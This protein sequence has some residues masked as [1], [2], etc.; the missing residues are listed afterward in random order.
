VTDPGKRKLSAKQ[1][2]ADIRSGMDSAGL[3][4]KYNLSDKGLESVCTRLVATGAL[5]ED[6][7]HRLAPRGSS[8]ETS[9][10]VAK[11]ARWQCPACNTPQT[12]EMV[13]CPVCGIVVE[14]FVARQGQMG[15]VSSADS[16][17]TQD[18]GQSERA[19]WMPVFI[20]IAA[21]ALVGSSLLLWSTYRAKHVPKVSDPGS[22]IQ[23]RQQGGTET[24]QTH[25]NIDEPE[26]TSKEYS[27]V[28]IVDGQ[29]A[30]APSAPVVAMPQEA[31]ERRHVVAP[32]EN[33]PPLSDKPQHVTGELRQFSSGNFKK[34]VVEASKTYPVLLQFYSDS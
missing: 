18:T 4:R 30:M 25:E 7:M 14:K 32:R 16:G 15:E 3:K 2:L 11:Q 6:Q 1:F 12:A 17:A 23:F 28:E 19:G 34:E 20:S 8:S 29:E 27:E 13:E 26:S 33:T 5:T 31:P 10:E 9:P 21:F 22:G 24:D